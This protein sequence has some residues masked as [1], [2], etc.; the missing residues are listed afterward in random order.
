MWAKWDERWIARTESWEKK[1]RWGLWGRGLPNK[2]TISTPPASPMLSFRSAPSAHT[3]SQFHELIDMEQESDLRAARSRRGWL[4][5]WSP[6]VS[7]KALRQHSRLQSNETPVEIMEGGDIV[8]WCNGWR[9]SEQEWK[10]KQGEG[11]KERKKER[12]KEKERK[13][14]KDRASHLS[15]P[16]HALG[17]RKETN[18]VLVRCDDF[19]AVTSSLQQRVKIGSCVRKSYALRVEQRLPEANW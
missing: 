13:R 9:A 6:P 5:E 3:T 4:H 2:R 19:I 14:K 12:K 16:P 15:S 8:K 7:C 18:T 11:E 10:K 1:R 17:G